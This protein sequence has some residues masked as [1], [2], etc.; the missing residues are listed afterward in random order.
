MNRHNKW[1]GLAAFALALPIVAA[2]GS[3]PLELFEAGDFE[4]AAAAARSTLQA[5]PGDLTALLVLGR[6]QMTLDHAAEAVATL[7][8]ATAEHPH[9][10]EAQYRLGQALSL[11]VAQANTWRRIM[12]SDDIGAAFSQA[13]ALEPANP[14]YR[15]ALFE[16]CRRAP[17]FVGGGRKRAVAEAAALARIDPARGLRAQ[18]A[19][20][21][22]DGK[23]E[24]AEARLRAAVAAA[25]DVPDH[26][27]ALGYFYQEQER[28]D[29]AFAV[30]EEIEQRFPQEAQAL[31][32]LGKT[33]AL[34][35]QRLATGENALQRYLQYKPRSGEPPLA[36]AHYR[37]GMIYE[38]RKALDAAAEHYALARDLDPRLDD[39][40]AALAA[41]RRR[42]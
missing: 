41:V 18:A 40:R 34:S 32:Q 30:F 8:R 1:S 15:W 24:Q 4:P 38:H 10:A 26:R 14:E 37:L 13:V 23:L 22:Q 29:P 17:G 21:A 11:R 25:P 33:A 27:F 7:R 2:A 12:L 3:R 35:G 39:A 28:W 20:L 6:A 19:L 31:F 16:F 42:G 5:D 36:W 9:S